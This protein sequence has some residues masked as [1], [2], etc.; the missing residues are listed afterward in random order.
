M[1]ERDDVRKINPL[2]VADV[3][4]IEAEITLRFTYEDHYKPQKGFFV[5]TN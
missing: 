5:T 2:G 3:M 4:S 1:G